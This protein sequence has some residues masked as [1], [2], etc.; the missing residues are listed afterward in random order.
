MKPFPLFPSFPL[1]LCTTL[2]DLQY[3]LVLTARRLY[4]LSAVVP[5]FGRVQAVFFVLCVALLTC[6]MEGFPRVPFKFL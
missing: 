1:I 2:L 3:M 5:S 6:T 4:P